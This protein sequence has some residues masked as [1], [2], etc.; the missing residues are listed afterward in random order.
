MHYRFQSLIA[1]FCLGINLSAQQSFTLQEAISYGIENSSA[2]KMKMIANEDANAQVKELKS[3][4]LPKVNGYVNYQYYLAVPAQPVADFITP[5]VYGVLFNENVIPERDLGAPNVF[6]FTLFQPNQLAAGVEVSSMIFDG[7]YL[8]SVK[9][10]KLYRELVQKEKSATEYSVKTSITKAYTAVLIAME[11]KK[12][13]A[14]NV[15]N[16]SKSLKEVEALYS[17]GFAESLDVDRLQLSY[18]NLL[19]E[20]ERV[21]Q[22]IDV[23]KN[24]LKFQMNF[25]S[26]LDINVTEDINTILSKMDQ[27]INLNLANLDYNQREEYGLI[28]L[29][30][31]LNDLDYKRTK[32]GYLPTARAT[33]SAQ[34]SL[35]RKNLFDNDETGI[36]PQ[37]ILGVSLNIPIYDGGDKSA[38][39]QRI[40]L[41][42]EKTALEK[43]DFEKSMTLQVKNALSSYQNAVKITENRKKAVDINQNIYNKTLI[44]FKEGVGSSVEV[45]QAESSLYQAQGAYT[46]ALYDLLSSNIELQTALGK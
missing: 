35:Q 16:L 17:N 2:I 21:D 25:P 7:S 15:E 46:N 11:N 33:A 29:G 34:G 24:I 9:A 4:G 36:I 20:M 5:S 13:I 31:S 8:Y 18:D 39:L 6:K 26:Q 44:K 32:A 19:T 14:K 41:K 10:A 42:Q 30:Q 3:I 38:K 1:I 27:N 22:M 37:S 43:M 40:K 23:S 12:V 28:T 45:T